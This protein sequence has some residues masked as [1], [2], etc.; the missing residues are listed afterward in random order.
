MKTQEEG[1]AYIHRLLDAHGE[2]CS[3]VRGVHLNQSLTGDYARSVMENP[4]ELGKTYAE[5][6]SKMFYHAF[7]VDKHQPFTGKGIRELIDRISPEYLT[8]EFITDDNAQH[9]E[10]LRQQRAALGLPLFDD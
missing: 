5:R 4:P 3:Y 7:A 10:Y 6:S 1:I 2:L 9:K 8:F